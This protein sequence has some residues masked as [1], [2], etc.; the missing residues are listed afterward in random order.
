M[1][2]TEWTKEK[3][4]REAANQK[5]FGSERACEMLTAFAERIEA[6]ERALPV[7]WAATDDDGHVGLGLTKAN[8]RA[9]TRPECSRLFPLFT[10][11]P[12]Q[13]A[14]V[15]KCCCGE[16]SVSGVRHRSD[17]PCYLSDG[18]GTPAQ[19]QPGWKAPDDFDFI[20][21]LQRQREWSTET[22][23]PGPRA[24]GVVDH[25]RKELREIEAD[26][27]DLKEWIDVV[28]L[29]LDGAW[30]S[31]AQPQEIIAAL[32]AKQ[33]KNEGRAWPDWRT[34]DPNKAIEH[35]RSRDNPAPP[36]SPAG[37]LD[38]I[39]ELSEC[40]Q[41]GWSDSAHAYRAGWNDCRAAMLAASPTPPKE[42]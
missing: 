24:Q 38:A 23:G 6:D 34:A 13:P 27:G 21:H 15:D 39:V 16:P 12:A 1:T 4:R 11:P 18:D 36:A 9:A 17:G 37:V 31:G 32:V 10:H 3:V 29:A 20:A 40:R 42:N 8:A 26:P 30:R 5:I 41:H 7:A 33:T 35:D 2:K 28:I 22:F 14:K 19:E 25:I